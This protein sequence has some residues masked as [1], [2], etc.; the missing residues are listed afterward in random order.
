MAFFT[1]PEPGPPRELQTDWV[2]PPKCYGTP[3][4]GAKTKVT[5]APGAPIDHRPSNKVEQCVWHGWTFPR[6][7]ASSCGCST[8]S[9]QYLHRV[10]HIKCRGVYPSTEANQGGYQC[11]ESGDSPKTFYQ[12][13]TTCTI[14]HS[15]QNW[16]KPFTTPI[17]P[18]LHQIRSSTTLLRQFFIWCRPAIHIGCVLKRSTVPD[19]WSRDTSFLLP[20]LSSESGLFRC[21]FRLYFILK[22]NQMFYFV[23]DLF[24]AELLRICSGPETRQVHIQCEHTLS[25]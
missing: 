15:S 4:F 22:I 24:Y 10:G 2:L 23:F 11:Y 3:C 6:A 12:S 21:C 25:D 8:F 17:K 14:L 18:D 13:S 16:K 19:S 9:R 20:A 7:R 5:G 1:H